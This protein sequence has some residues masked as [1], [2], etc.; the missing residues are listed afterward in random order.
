MRKLHELFDHALLA[1][2]QPQK[3]TRPCVL[4][5]QAD[6]NHVGLEGAV[7]SCVGIDCRSLRLGKRN[8]LKPALPRRPVHQ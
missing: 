7:S 1:L 4:I 8:I 5:R 3:R 6:F 2:E